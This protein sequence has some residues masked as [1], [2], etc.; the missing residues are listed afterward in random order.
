[1]V[2]AAAGNGGADAP[3]AYPAAYDDV[4]AVTA[5]DSA[6]SLYAQANQGTYIDIAAP[7]VDVLS[8]SLDSAYS[9]TSGTSFAAAHV[10]GVVALMLSRNPGMKPADIRRAL[11][12]GAADLGKPGIDAEFGAGLVDALSALK[13]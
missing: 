3:P 1:V 6:D 7:G 8:P 13:Q 5:T 12:A 11:K 2:V 9:M 4:L 10:S